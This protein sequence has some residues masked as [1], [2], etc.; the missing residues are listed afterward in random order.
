MFSHR[1]QPRVPAFDDRIRQAAAA[2]FTAEHLP[3]GLVRFKRGACAALIGKA[4]NGNPR[5]ETAGILVG[6]ELAE[7]VDNGYQ[8]FFETPTGHRFPAL[9]GQL[10][11]LHA[12]EEDLRKALGMESWYNESLGTVNQ[13]HHYDRVL[14]R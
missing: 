1:Q 3:S 4:A 13:S 14:G 9:A 5:I 2:G 8:K 6:G 10:K 12:F 7:L 11:A